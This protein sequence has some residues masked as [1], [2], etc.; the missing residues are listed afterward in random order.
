VALLEPSSLAVDDIGMGILGGLTKRHEEAA[1]PVPLE[2]VDAFRRAVEAGD[3][4]GAS[5]IWAGCWLA[6]T[7]ADREAIGAV[8]AGIPEAVTDEYPVLRVAAAT[9]GSDRDDGRADTMW[10][11]TEACRRAMEQAGDRLRA[12]EL[13]YIGTGH[14]AG[15]RL[16]GR[17]DESEALGAVLVERLTS[18]A[19]GPVL[20]GPNLAW[21]YLQWGLTAT[22][23]GE[24]TAA[25]ARYERAWEQGRAPGTTRQVAAHAA[26][27]LAL[28]HAVQGNAFQAEEWL[29]EYRA[30]PVLGPVQYL[31]D[32]GAHVAAGLLALDRGDVVA[33]ADAVSALD[34]EAGVELWP[35]VAYLTVCHC[36]AFGHPADAV[37]AL[38]EAVRSHSPLPPGG[39]SGI[40]LASARAHALTGVE[41]CGG[42]ATAPDRAVL[43][44]SLSRLHFLA[45]QYDHA[46]ALGPTGT[47]PL[48]RR[49]QAKLAALASVARTRR[50]PAVPTRSDEAMALVQ[51]IDAVH[52][53]LSEP[54]GDPKGARKLEDESLTADIRSRRH[55]PTR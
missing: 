1:P 53:L 7:L 2:E 51:R 15:L 13:A 24:V 22:L 36:L 49:G 12:E 39:F 29:A 47:G 9:A 41:I 6:L 20:S 55:P 46:A 54:D 31:I 37:G 35:F 8:V 38:D 44:L 48:R 43:D 19:E 28:I 27:N 26:A 30:V 21:V 23:Q 18:G 14:L 32:V 11:H 52:A 34:V 17:P 5:R 25:T 40:L 50:R 4:A 16:T 45:G 10:A 33:A 42:A 3:W